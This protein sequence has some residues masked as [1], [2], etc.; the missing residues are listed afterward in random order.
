MVDKM[1][2]VLIIGGGPA[3]S[4]LGYLLS[5]K[6]YKTTII[7]K[8]KFPRSKLCG[9]LLTEK[10]FKLIM[11]LY[12]IDRNELESEPFLRFST[13]GY[14]LRYR[15]TKLR[16]KNCQYPFHFVDRAGFDN[17]LL[18]RAKDAGCRVIEDEP[19]VGVDRLKGMVTT[20]NKA[21]K[22][23]LVVGADGAS[24]I[25]SRALP[26][27]IIDRNSWHKNCAIGIESRIKKKDCPLTTDRPI[28]FFGFCNAG[29]SWIFPNQ[30]T[31]LIG[32]G[33]INQ[34]N[35][36]QFLNLYKQFISAIGISPE[37]KPAYRSHLIP[38]GNFLRKPF[39]KNL[40]LVGDA[41]GFVDPLTGEGIFC[42]IKSSELL[43]SAIVSSTNVDNIGELYFDLLNKVILSELDKSMAIRNKLSF[44]FN[45]NHKPIYGLPM[46]LFFS[47]F[48]DR[49][50]NMFHGMNDRK[51]RQ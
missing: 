33:G 20:K 46:G 34:Y 18:T 8:Q 40:F 42:A 16:S 2:E 7:E 6:G 27:G 26:H 22:A 47:L 13:V 19:V 25:V 21:Y 9:G 44:L 14:E 48:S 37:I 39:F 5:N 24:S 49:F 35:R 10:T 28:I 51:E 41:A 32:M 31:L 38:Y 4:T 29:Y 43:A 50:V 3:G 15:L 11:R 30:D 12:Q 17:F 36:G 1:Q 23:R 45:R